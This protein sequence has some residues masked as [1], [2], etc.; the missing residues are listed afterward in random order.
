MPSITI[1]ALAMNATNSGGIGILNRDLLVIA[2]KALIIIAGIAQIGGRSFG[3]SRAMASGRKI[4][5]RSDMEKKFQCST[6]LSRWHS[7]NT[8][9]AKVS[10]TM[11]I[12]LASSLP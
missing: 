6:W 11:Q 4:L 2:K 10:T 1:T 3:N 9:T 8:I 7:A 5:P 12:L